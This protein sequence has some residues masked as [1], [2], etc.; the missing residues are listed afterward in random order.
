[1]ADFV[2]DDAQLKSDRLLVSYNAILP[3]MAYVHRRGRSEV[4]LADKNAMRRWL[5]RVLVERQ[6]GGAAV[7][8]VNRCVNV[9]QGTP[10]TVFSERSLYKELGLTDEPSQEFIL[11]RGKRSPQESVL[12]LFIAYMD[13]GLS[14]PSMNPFHSGNTPE[15]DHIIPKA[16]VARLYQQAGRSID[17]STINNIGNYRVIAKDDNRHKAD[18][19]PHEFYST[20]QAWSVFLARHII[21]EDVCIDHLIDLET[22]ERFVDARRKLLFDRIRK[23]LTPPDLA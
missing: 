10:T 1:V 21:P 4:G 3:L 7:T 17:S 23:V 16:K 8:T 13:S 12:P 22:Y 19:W 11:D 18:K 20:P 9:I 5:Y 2:R 14:F 6:F 15:V